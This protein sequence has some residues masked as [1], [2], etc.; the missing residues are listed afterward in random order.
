MKI[1][2]ARLL[3]N[4]VDI[5]RFTVTK[6][7]KDS[8]ITPALRWVSDQDDCNVMITLPGESRYVSSIVLRFPHVLGRVPIRV[9]PNV[10]SYDRQDSPEF[11]RLHVV[12]VRCV[13]P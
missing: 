11:W 8:C 7:R 5:N 10:L 9:F 13:S 6:N 2:L 4:D 12:D 1:L 3:Q